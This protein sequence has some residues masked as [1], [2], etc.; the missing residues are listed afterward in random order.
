MWRTYEGNSLT[1]CQLYDDIIFS[2]VPCA[3]AKGSSMKIHNFWAATTGYIV[4]ASQILILALVDPSSGEVSVRGSGYLL[5]A[6]GLATVMVAI[7][8]RSSE[9]W[10][11]FYMGL[12]GAVAGSVTAFAETQS[13]DVFTGKLIMT[14]FLVALSVGLFWESVQEVDSR[15]VLAPAP[16]I[17]VAP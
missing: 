5:T 15:Q 6:S 13:A 14:M 11:T 10:S 12:L 7:C 2:T 8:A 4:F 9:R 3:A 17:T 1:I 16:R